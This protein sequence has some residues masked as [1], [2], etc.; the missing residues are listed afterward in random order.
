MSVCSLASPVNNLLQNGGAELDPGVGWTIVSGD[1][2]QR[3]ADST[4]S[5]IFCIATLLTI[6]FSVNAQAFGM[7]F[8]DVTESAGIDYFG[9]SFGVSWGDVNADGWPDIWAG[10]HAQTPNLYINNKDGTFSDEVFRV[11]YS[12]SDRHGAAWTDF[13]NDG[14][15][16]LL[17]LTGAGVS[18]AMGQNL[19]FVNEGGVLKER[20]AS[21]G[22]ANPLGRGRTPLWFDWNGDGKLDVFLTNVIRPDGQVP[23][24]LFTQ[25]DGSFVDS[26]DQTGLPP[27]STLYAQLLTIGEG[28]TRP[29][30]ILQGIHGTPY[31]EALFDYGDA[32]FED[33]SHLMP[34]AG[35]S[36]FGVRDVAIADF[37][38]DLL[39]DLVLVRLKNAS[40]AIQTDPNHIAAR[41][42]LG[43]DA[44]GFKFRADGN[45]QFQIG[46]RVNIKFSDIYIGANGIHPED[47]VFS[48]SSTDAD[49]VGLSEPDLENPLG[50]YIGYDPAS[51]LWQL[52]VRR[53]DSWLDVGILV[54]TEVPITD[55]STVNFENSDG[56]MSDQLFLQ[57]DFGFADHGVIPEVGA[58]TPCTSVATADFDNDMDMDLYLV[59]HG[60]ATNSPNKLYENLGNG[61]FREVPGSGD[62]AGSMVGLGESVAIADYDR[63]GYVDLFVTN[64]YGGDPLNQ[65]PSQ[66]FRNMGGTNHWLEV[67][68]EGAPSNRD[69]VGARVRVTA[70]GVTQIRDHDGGMHRF[71]QN[72]QRLHFGLAEETVVDKLEVLW[73]GGIRQVI[74]NITVDQ[75][76]RVAEPDTFSPSLWLQITGTAEGGTISLSIVDINVSLTT[77]AG[78]TSGQVAQALADTVNNSTRLSLLGVKALSVG[79]IVYFNHEVTDLSSTDSGITL[80]LSIGEALPPD[81]DVN[82]D[83]AV[84]AAD[85][86]FGTQ[87]ISNNTTLTPLQLS[88]GDVAPLSGVQP[89]PDGQFTTADLLIIERKVLGL[90][91]F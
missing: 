58:S 53:S 64:G 37:N 9:D 46:P 3:S 41:L 26:V 66:L 11:E 63:D 61:S 62:A 8:K 50:V 13:D 72:F 51:G 84:N 6:L 24:A 56:A 70:G 90:I 44:Q 54:T 65:G 14:D 57:S 27:I 21:Y 69:G 19:F 18:P 60:S 80:S 42:V 39:S 91:D 32:P 22:L 49:A 75:I 15:Q 36:N 85:V 29:S 5:D 88:R 76:V 59:C 10:N 31:P 74:E 48:L 25:V 89:S 68:L 87:L 38:G 78:L 2:Q 82:L 73:P 83:G 34:P 86:L 23:S 81:G 16:D 35:D 1:W 4:H 17:I 7:Q 47:V 45:V 71:S 55:L 79:D 33:L 20:A 43:V 67:D 52:L 12:F 30:I 40:E 28:N 77:T